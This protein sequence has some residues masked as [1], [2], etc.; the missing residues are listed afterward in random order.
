M[1]FHFSIEKFYINRKDIDVVNQ[2]ARK[3]RKGRKIQTLNKI[4]RKQK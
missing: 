1:I 3:I 2:Y 4:L